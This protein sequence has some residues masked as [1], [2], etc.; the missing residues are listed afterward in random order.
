MA[1]N[2]V[3]D[4]VVVYEIHTYEKKRRMVRMMTKRIGEGSHRASTKYQMIR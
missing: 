1:D 2:N 3:D 4:V